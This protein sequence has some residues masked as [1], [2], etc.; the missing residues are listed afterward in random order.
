MK[1]LLLYLLI[2]AILAVWSAIN[3]RNRPVEDP[4]LPPRVRAVSVLSAYAIVALLW[5]LSVAVS[6]WALLNGPSNR[7]GPERGG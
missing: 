6:L 3:N 5:P 4:E 7:E 2:G 1:G